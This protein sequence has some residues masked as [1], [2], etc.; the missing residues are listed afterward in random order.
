LDAWTGRLWTKTIK[1]RRKSTSIWC[2]RPTQRK[3]EKFHRGA[4]DIESRRSV[5]RAKA[6]NR[7]DMESKLGHI[8]SYL[9]AIALGYVAVSFV[10][11]L[12]YIGEIGYWSITLFGIQDMIQVS[13]TMTRVLLLYAVIINVLYF[14]I[15]SVLKIFPPYK[16]L[17]KGVYNYLS[18]DKIS[19]AALVLF[20]YGI[21]LILNYFKYI[22]IDSE[23]IYL[24]IL[25]RVFVIVN[26]LIY[27][28]WVSATNYTAK[29]VQIA[30]LIALILNINGLGI[31]W[32]RSDRSADENIVSVYLS[33]GAC[34]TSRLVRT[35]ASGMIFYNEY[36]KKYEFRRLETINTMSPGRQ[37]V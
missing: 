5:A 20:P 10:I 32:A 13:S 37:C 6:L 2:R 4:P 28:I 26:T 35:V 18:G 33:N 31:A 27:V 14:F 11:N 22:D 17:S 34:I 29:F 23:N 1:K 25:P 15:H 9:P 12:G 16:K 24:S 36:S 8:I 3:L 30:F 7:T 21:I 19:L